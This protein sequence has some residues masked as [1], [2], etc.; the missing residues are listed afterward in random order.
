MYGAMP[1]G[2]LNGPNGVTGYQSAD[3]ICMPQT[4]RTHAFEETG[5]QCGG[6]HHAFSLAHTQRLGRAGNQTSAANHGVRLAADNR[7][8]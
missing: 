3:P 2:S 1:Q 6:L 8:P 7:Q 5:A 4:H